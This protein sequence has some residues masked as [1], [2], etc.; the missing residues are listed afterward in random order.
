MSR[1]V[2]LVVLAGAV[3]VQACATTPAPDGQ[4]ADAPSGASLAELEALYLA[5]Q[6]SALLRVSEAD[7]AFM[8][9]MIHH[10]AQALVMSA[11][12][13]T[14][15][16]SPV[17]RTL[18][19]RIINA[20]RDEIANMQRWLGD[21]GR[22]VPEVDESGAVRMEMRGEHAMHGA[23]HDMRMPGM[24]SPEQLQELR[25]ARGRDFDRLFLTYMIQHHQGAV[26]MVHELF[27]TD[28]AAQDDLVFKIA[29]DIQVDQISEID[30]M[31]RMLD[32]LPDS[33]RR[34]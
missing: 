20:Q 15:G 4:P 24:L 23:E 21:R 6:D 22:P 13:P 5:R 9:G 19:A 32:A 34:P 14:N 7:V 11:L 2:S 26:T 31:Q 3:A 28:G 12:A 8:T 33:G 30:R 27:A 29:S 18:T 17:M 25:D 10:H 16:A 1:L